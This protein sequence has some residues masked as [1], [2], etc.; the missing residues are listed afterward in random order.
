MRTWRVGMVGY[1]WAAGA[2]LTAL[3][4]IANVEV[5]AICTSRTDAAE[6]LAGRGRGAADRHRPRL[7]RAP[8]PR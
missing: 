8:S 6:A 1:G 5:V 7:R 2:H 4:R 3:A